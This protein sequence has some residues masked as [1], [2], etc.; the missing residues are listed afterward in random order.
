[1]QVLMIL[2]Q[3]WKSGANIYLDKADDRIAIDNQKL[4]PGEVMQSAEYNFKKI[5]DWFQSWKNASNEKITIRKALHTYCG[6]E[7]NEK[8]SEW[9]CDDTDSLMLFTDWTIFLAKNGWVDIYDD[10]R[11]YENE[12][13]DRMVRELY[14]RAVAYAKKGV[15][16]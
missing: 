16:A 13:S 1:M 9:L 11:N 10:F 4:I 15:G 8:L 14:I 12:E 2:S 6:W 3:I 7:K 5:A